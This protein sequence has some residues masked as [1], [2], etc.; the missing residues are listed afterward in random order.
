MCEEHEL[1]FQLNCLRPGRAD[2]FFLLGDWD[3]A[4]ADLGAV[5][6]DPSASALN[7]GIVLQQLGRVRARRGDPGAVEALDDSLAL[8]EPYDEAQLIAPAHLARAEAA[9][10]AGDLATAATHVEAAL[11]LRAAC[12]TSWTRRDLALSARRVGVDW[13]PEGEQ[14]EPLSFIVAGDHRGLSA[15]WAEHGCMY[16]AADAL[17][18][19]D[20]VDDVRRAHEQLIA[21][22]ARPRAQWR[23]A[24][25]GS[26]ARATC[27]AGRGPAPEPTPPGSPS[28]SWRWRRL[29]ADGLT[30]AEVAERLVVSQKTVDH[31]VSAVLTKLGVSSR[32]HVRRAAAD[33]GLDLAP[34]ADAAPTAG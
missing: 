2:A 30:N 34:P 24:G 25:C 17:V 19:S 16:E 28:A 14:A 18:D 3:A 21:L 12:S 33:L 31:H 4:V 15:F 11:A 10:L 27:P 8:V 5:L 13:V 22:G 20:D 23:R 29:L 32:R 9:W 26:W 1:R 7:R 6:V